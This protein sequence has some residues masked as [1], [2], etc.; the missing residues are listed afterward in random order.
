MHRRDPKEGD[1]Q[2]TSG[3]QEQAPVEGGAS[4]NYAGV[5]QVSPTW[6]LF[7]VQV[8]KGQKQGEGLY[9]H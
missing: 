1:T 4:Q 2:P 7:L 6:A 3:Q 5:Y 8:R 9:A